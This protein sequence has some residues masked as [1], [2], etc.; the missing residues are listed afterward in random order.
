MAKQET[1]SNPERAYEGYFSYCVSV[2]V[3]PAPFVWWRAM[4]DYLS[5]QFT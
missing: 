1:K 3:K 4:R 5:A 2:G